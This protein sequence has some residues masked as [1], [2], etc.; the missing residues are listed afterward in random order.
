MNII[1]KTREPQNWNNLIPTV[2]K[3]LDLAD[4]DEIEVEPSIA[5]SIT[6]EIPKNIPDVIGWMQE[7]QARIGRNSVYNTTAQEIDDFVRTRLNL[8]EHVDVFVRFV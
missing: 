2:R 6:V 7:T 5:Q 3:E 4:S 8:P 1:I